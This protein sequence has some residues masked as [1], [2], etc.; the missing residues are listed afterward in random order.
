MIAILCLPWLFRADD[1]SKL[2]SVNV[3][4]TWQIPTVTSPFN[5]IKQC[6]ILVGG[7][8]SY[9]FRITINTDVLSGASIIECCHQVSVIFSRPTKWTTHLGWYHHNAAAISCTTNG[10]G[11]VMVVQA[12]IW[13]EVGNL[14]L[15]RVDICPVTV[16]TCRVVIILGI[17]WETQV[18]RTTSSMPIPF[19][20]RNAYENIK[21]KLCVSYWI[22]IYYFTLIAIMY[23][24]TDGLQKLIYYLHLCQ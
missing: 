14:I 8:T 1:T 18:I 15:S 6:S 7:T 5:W 4:T 22:S 2:S 13:W 12:C 20:S 19:S 3:W 17:L 16:R 23:W 24:A 9:Y 10:T 11:D 21:I